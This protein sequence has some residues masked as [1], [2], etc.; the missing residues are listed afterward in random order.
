LSSPLEQE[1]VGLAQ[2]TAAADGFQFSEACLADLEVVVE[3]GVALLTAE[4]RPNP[5]AVE[6]ARTRLSQFVRAMVR[7]ARA[8]G[9]D[10]LQEWTLQSARR[11]LCPLPPWF[12]EPCD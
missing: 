8:Q 6:T 12:P 10:E 1:F 11:W 7:E 2:S 4:G 5:Q 3:K 9:I